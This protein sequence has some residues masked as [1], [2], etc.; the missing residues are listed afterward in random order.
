MSHNNVFNGISEPEELPEPNVPVSD[1]R[2]QAS[3]IEE[4][5][6]PY[7]EASRRSELVAVSSE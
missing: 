6:G 4:V 5:R 7:E 3:N 2:S 1:P